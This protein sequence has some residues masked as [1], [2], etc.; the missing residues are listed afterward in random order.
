MRKFAVGSMVLALA[1]VI[2]AGAYAQLPAAKQAE[3]DAAGINS[4]HPGQGSTAN[5]A[6]FSNLST[7]RSAPGPATENTDTMQYDDGN[8][9]ALP[10]IFGAIYGNR[11]N[12]GKPAGT[13]LSTI[14]LNSF[15]FYFMEDSLPDTG[16]FFQPADPLNA[17]SI[18]VRTSVNVGGLN[19]SGQSF[20][21]PVLNVI[22]QTALGTT[23]GFFNTFYLGAWCLN[24]ALTFPINNEVIGLATNGPI[25]KG[26]TAISASGGPVPFSNQA[27]NAILRANVTSPNT[28][29]VELMS[30]EVGN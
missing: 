5:G 24:T 11:F 1:L 7:A 29:P 4:W 22:P 16:L 17:G 30:F 25:Q 21:N 18:S 23:G 9:T 2:A 15:S 14:T 28:V 26:Y 13:P 12:G 19:N 6:R 27:F 3:L 8:L 20:S 10:I